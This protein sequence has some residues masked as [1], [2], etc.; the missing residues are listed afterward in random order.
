MR[1][2]VVKLK[3]NLYGLKQAPRNWFL[4]LHTWLTN[5]G[6]VQNTADP[7]IYVLKDDHRHLIISVYVDD[8]PLASPVLS[9]LEE[10]KAAFKQDFPIK[11][12]GEAS[13]LL[14]T[15]IDRNKN[16]LALHQSQYIENMLYKFGLQDSTPSSTP[17]T[18]D[19]SLYPRE[20]PEHVSPD[21]ESGQGST[22]TVP[23]KHRQ[24]SL[25]SLVYSSRYCYSCRYSV[26]PS[27]KSH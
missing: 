14:G 11:D 5:Y 7:C 27:E 1:E 12:L 19:F 13:W 6:F 23:Q 8:L 24:S 21:L 20:D 25:G 10:L 2:G 3:N 4:T 15:A 26:T 22:R 17:M 18:T 9:H 16:E